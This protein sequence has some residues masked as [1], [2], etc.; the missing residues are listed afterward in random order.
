MMK[1]PLGKF[2]SILTWLITALVSLNEGLEAFGYGAKTWNM[3]AM[4]P[5]LMMYMHYVAGVAGLISLLMLVGAL[6]G[7]GCCRDGKGSC[8]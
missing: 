8:K 1:S 3:L 5:Q 2:L 7:H 4:N 6:L